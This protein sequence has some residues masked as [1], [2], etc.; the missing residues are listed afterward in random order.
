ME[1]FMAQAVAVARRGYGFVDPNPLV[2]AVI[3]RDGVVVASGYHAHYG[4]PHAERA[5]LDDARDRGVATQ[6]AT[7]YVTL[8]PC[9]HQGKTPPCAPALVEAGISRVVVGSLDP[10]PKVNGR[11]LAILR[12]GGVEVQLAKDSTECEALNETFFHFI[13]TGNPFVI[14]KYAMSLDGRTALEPGRPFPL[15]GPESLARVHEDRSRYPVILTGVGTVLADNPRLT[16]RPDRA[17]H[18]PMRVIVDSR[19]RTPVSSR[20][21]KQSQEDH[22]TVIATTVTDPAAWKTYEDSGCE[23]VA[24]PADMQ[25]HVSLPALIAEVGRRRMTAVYAEAGSHLAAGLMASGC[26]SKIEAFITPTLMGRPT[27]PS[28]LAGTALPTPVTGLTNVTTQ[29]YGNDI[30]IEG[31]LPCSQE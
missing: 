16:A 28:P 4:G 29:R 3:V 12:D 30:L 31:T 25:G 10:N 22:L 19:L 2:G 13:R 21:V 27:A 23:V 6:G 15:S 1:D 17:A 26:I 24:L 5:A 20:V 14:L 8:E 9:S 11:G 7:M 18:Q